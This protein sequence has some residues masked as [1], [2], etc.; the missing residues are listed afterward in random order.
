MFCSIEAIKSLG[1]ATVGQDSFAS[2]IQPLQASAVMDAATFEVRSGTLVVTSDA[3]G[4]LTGDGT[5]S[6]NVPTGEFTV[7]SNGLPAAEIVA[8]VDISY[9]SGATYLGSNTNGLP[10][11]YTLGS[12]LS[13]GDSVIVQ[14]P[15]SSM[16]IVGFSGS[17]WMTR[18]ALDFMDT[19]E[20]YKLATIV[21][22]STALEI[23]DDGNYAW[24]GT[25]NGRVYRISGLNNAR[26]YAT[27]DLDSSATAVTVSLWYLN[28]IVR[29]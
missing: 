3:S 4:N 9:P 24:V 11:K 25:N 22:T 6:F 1:F 13:M 16:F 15:V 28:R 2:V 21:G 7:E 5:G 14:D 19:P 8:T 10:F 12:A 20:W 23:S 18:G 29:A 26:S 27:A 17:V